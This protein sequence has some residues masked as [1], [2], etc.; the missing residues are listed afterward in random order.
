[1]KK[2]ILTLALIVYSFVL[3]AQ[4][5][6]GGRPDDGGA[7]T[8]EDTSMPIPTATLLLVGFGT[9]YAMVKLKKYKQQK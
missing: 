5:I 9:G 1:M 4:P 2:F 7:G 6:P 8:H 3:I